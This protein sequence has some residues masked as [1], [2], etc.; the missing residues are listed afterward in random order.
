MGE[1]IEFENKRLEPHKLAR[2]PPDGSL[3]DSNKLN[4]RNKYLMLRL[5]G[6]F[7]EKSR[8]QSRALG[9]QKV[10]VRCRR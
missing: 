2:P 9:N 4:R 7:F 8:R 3:I 5:G 1:K 6:F 10:L